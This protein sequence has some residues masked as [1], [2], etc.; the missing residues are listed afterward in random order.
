MCVGTTVGVPLATST[1]RRERE[2]I[3]LSTTVSE[4]FP[5]LLPCLRQIDSQ[6]EEGEELLEKEEQNVGKQR[7]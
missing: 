2:N 6:S 4:V 1:G 3:E 7:T 5:S